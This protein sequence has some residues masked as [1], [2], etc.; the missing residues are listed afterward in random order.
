MF[1]KWPDYD[2][3]LPKLRT[4]KFLKIKTL[5]LC[6]P[7]V[8]YLNRPT[9]DLANTVDYQIYAVTLLDTGKLTYLA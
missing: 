9:L 4:V 1:L 5:L 6:R 2:K 3:V 8:A 7:L